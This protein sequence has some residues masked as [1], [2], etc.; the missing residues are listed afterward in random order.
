MV[1]IIIPIIG[2]ELASLPP[3]VGLLFS[4]S[5]SYTII[6]TVQLMGRGPPLSYDASC[7][8]TYFTSQLGEMVTRDHLPQ[9]LELIYNS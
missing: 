6:S 2:Q 3:T 5:I 9:Q 4:F 1:A 8:Q 7:A